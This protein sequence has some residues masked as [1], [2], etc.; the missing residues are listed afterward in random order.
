MQVHAH[1]DIN[2]DEI[3]YEA[4]S[5]VWGDAADRTP[6]ECDSAVVEVPHTL[7]TAL[8]H[9]RQL[10]R[11]RT[12]WADALCINQ[13]D[14][15]EKSIQVKAM[16]QIYS[17]AAQ[18]LMWQGEV[19]EETRDS[20]TSLAQICT[21]ATLGTDS[22]EWQDF[23]RLAQHA[24]SLEHV[25]E[26]DDALFQ[27][28][29]PN[30]ASITAL[31]GRPYFGRRWIGQEIILA[32]KAVMVMGSQ[33]LDWAL[34]CERLPTFD[35]LQ[36]V[37]FST[38]CNLV[39]KGQSGLWVRFMYMVMATR[40]RNSDPSQASTEIHSLYD[41]LWYMSSLECFDPRDRL[42]ALLHVA[43]DVNLA[44]DTALIPDYTMNEAEVL[45]NLAIWV[46]VRKRH[47]S[48]MSYAIQ[49][50]S[51]M[52]EKQFDLPSWVPPSVFGIQKTK[53]LQYQFTR[54]FKL[55]PHG[56]RVLG[57]E[58]RNASPMANIIELS[59]DRRILSITG[60]IIDCVK[61]CSS[62][63]SSEPF[64]LRDFRIFINTGFSDKFG[65]SGVVDLAT[66]WWL[67]DSL[68]VL[69]GTEND[70]LEVAC[71]DRFVQYLCDV[72]V[73]LVIRMKASPSSELKSV[74]I[75][76]I[77][78][79]GE[80]TMWQPSQDRRSES[81]QPFFND[82]W[83]DLGAISRRYRFCK[84]HENRIGFIAGPVQPGDLICALDGTQ[85]PW[86]IRPSG[87]GNYRLIGECCLENFMHG[88]AFELSDIPD[89]MIRLC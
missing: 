88:E 18:V 19:T 13:E 62:L 60:K 58:E 22:K 40:A 41:A 45:H 42:F 44:V 6:I 20:L 61:R 36:T 71:S 27:A 43:P 53:S 9:L 82:L 72:L 24:N 77:K 3:P 23:L 56:L 74:I 85:I 73:Y 54:V 10:D 63:V 83:N 87:S 67:R 78:Y 15:E 32:R 1:S 48:Y 69:C 30:W 35:H 59:K 38:I 75:P 4:L 34:I 39:A 2:E 57:S 84:T 76:Y 47:P 14:A 65:L 66:A 81:N 17:K 49:S 89:Q 31:L 70:W 46:I 68:S 8:R 64:K 51:E 52:Q 55:T 50:P 5:Y 26:V 33:T 29:N 37:A 21:L 86:V 7:Y 79:L 11:P 25:D 12:L 16:G 28:K 80:L